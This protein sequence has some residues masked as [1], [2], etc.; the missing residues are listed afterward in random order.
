VDTLLCDVDNAMAAL[1]RGTTIR[2]ATED[3]GKAMDTILCGQADKEPLTVR[4]RAIFERWRAPKRQSEWLAGRRAA[5]RVL[6]AILALDDPRSVEVGRLDTGAPVVHGHGNVVV[7]ISHAGDVA[8][9]VAAQFSVGVDVELDESRPKCLWNAVLCRAEQE[10]LAHVQEHDR[11]HEGNRLWTSKE[12]IS[13][14]GGWGA[15]KNFK[16]IDCSV[17]PVWVEGR[18]IHHRC[19]AVDGY[20]ITLAQEATMGTDHG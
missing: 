18:A 4:E 1:C 2:F 15:T 14:V 9:A 5:K 16:T 20:V 3:V 17:N 11:D 13:K 19:A 10:K 7:S 8:I 6:C 12:A